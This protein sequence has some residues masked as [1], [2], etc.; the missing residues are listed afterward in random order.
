MEEG[1]P[2]L[3]RPP[4]SVDVSAAL[5]PGSDSSRVPA[6]PSDAECL[7]L[8]CE[9]FPPLNPKSDPIPGPGGLPVGSQWNEP[10]QAKPKPLRKLILRYCPPVLKENLPFGVVTEQDVSAENGGSTLNPPQVGEEGVV[11]SEVGKPKVGE[12]DSCLPTKLMEKHEDQWTLI[13]ARKKGSAGSHGLKNPTRTSD[14]LSSQRNSNL[15]QVAAGGKSSFLK[16]QSPFPPKNP[17]F[18]SGSSFSKSRSGLVAAAT[19]P[20]YFGC[21]AAA[22]DLASPGP[23]NVH[24]APCSSPLGPIGPPSISACPGPKKSLFQ[25]AR[26]AVRPGH[27]SLLGQ[28]ATAVNNTKGGQNLGEKLE[29]ERVDIRGKIQMDVSDLKEKEKSVVDKKDDLLTR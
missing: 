21:L 26:A 9:S 14:P 13:R 7:N 29:K 3:P 4:G 10:L 6:P 12:E 17:D 25:H 8:G 20:S 11:I 5:P 19:G 18:P 24:V 15:V 16:P 22:A 23:P 1:V 2:G 27:W 28:V